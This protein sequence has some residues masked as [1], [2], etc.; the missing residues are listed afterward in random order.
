MNQV[1][2]LTHGVA[3]KQG[4]GGQQ[5]IAMVER[6]LASTVS[7]Y[8]KLTVNFPSAF[9]P[10]RDRPEVGYLLRGKV[11]VAGEPSPYV[12]WLH[13]YILGIKAA[14]SDE[15]CN[16]V[17]AFLRVSETV[18]LDHLWLWPL[19]RRCMLEMGWSGRVIY[20]SHNAEALARDRWFDENGS[21]DTH[22]IQTLA[23]I[24]RYELSLTS[25]AD[26]VICCSSDDAR[27]YVTHGARDVRVVPNG[28]WSS[29]EDSP[30]ETSSATAIY[31]AS[32]WFPNV[33][34][35][36]R[37]VVPCLEASQ[38]I[39]TLVVTGGVADL[40]RPLVEDSRRRWQVPHHVE[41]KGHMDWPDFS[42]VY[43]SSGLV[44]NP[45]VTGTGTNIKTA[46]ALV[47]GKPLLTT[48]LGARGFDR[49]AETAQNWFLRDTVTGWLEVLTDETT[50]KPARGMSELT[51][52]AVQRQMEMELQN[53]L[54]SK[55][56]RRS[57]SRYRDSTGAAAK[58]GHV[59][60]TAAG[61]DLYSTRG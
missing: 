3:D 34:G 15:I 57:E 14:S 18:I 29:S 25:S 61:V 55:P 54:Q 59:N 50:W 35:F 20:S 38:E 45:V 22:V 12:W 19:L 58:S 7:K 49:W 9:A 28:A 48:S 42:Q 27:W 31:A 16:S 23:S 43:R 13:D 24:R 33:E 51:W 37:L 1:L 56:L 47:D 10:Y 52:D 40:V 60:A 11:E 36:A 46:E 4:G 53:A 2:F 44:L 17:S 6:A 39:I 8:A 32:G 26:T 30:P 41:L 5:R 21:K